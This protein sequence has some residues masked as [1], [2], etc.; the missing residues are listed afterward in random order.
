[1]ECFPYTTSSCDNGNIK[2]S[3]NAYVI[4]KVRSFWWKRLYIGS[5]L[6]YCNVS[7]IQPI[8]HFMPKPK[9]PMNVGRET[10]GKLVLSSAIV[11]T[12]GKAL[13]TA[14]LKSFKKLIVSKFS[15]PP[16]IFGSHSP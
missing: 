9:P 15:L 3:V 2:F 1:M 7:C 11:C 4:E 6:K 8:I 13:Y 5:F 12:S 16:Y 14:S 10:I